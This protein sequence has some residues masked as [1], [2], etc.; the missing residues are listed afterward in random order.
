MQVS[1]AWVLA[2]HKIKPYLALCW[3]NLG[4]F[5][6]QV[7]PPIRLWHYCVTHSFAQL[8]ERNNTRLLFSQSGLDTLLVVFTEGSWLLVSELCEEYINPSQSLEKVFNKNNSRR[9]ARQMVKRD[10][11][12]EETVIRRNG[13]GAL[14]QTYKW[15]HCTQDLHDHLMLMEGSDWRINNQ[16]KYNPRC[17]SVNIPKISWGGCDLF[18]QA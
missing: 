4:Y 2:N 11:N 10:S 1:F 3:D 6:L 5:L 9:R 7:I 16:E 12:L 18:L 15:L 14:H 13:L 17:K 8:M